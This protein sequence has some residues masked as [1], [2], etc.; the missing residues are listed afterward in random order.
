[1]DFDNGKGVSI[2]DNGLNKSALSK[3]N[4]KKSF[5]SFELVKLL[6]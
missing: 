6:I 5:H 1:M 3:K 4:M 2:W